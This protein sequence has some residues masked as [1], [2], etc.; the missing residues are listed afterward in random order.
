MNARDNDLKRNNR[1]VLVR[2]RTQ[3]KYKM[4]AVQQNPKQSEAE[5]TR[6]RANRQHAFLIDNPQIGYVQKTI[7]WDRKR[8]RRK[9]GIRV[10][11]SLNYIFS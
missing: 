10:Y 7:V 9:R 11:M 8:R 2:K 1:R 3:N 6:E 5:E 4:D